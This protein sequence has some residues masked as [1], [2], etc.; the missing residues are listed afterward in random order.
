[1]AGKKEEK[2]TKAGAAWLA[3]FFFHFRHFIEGQWQQALN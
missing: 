3:I 1:M 2:E